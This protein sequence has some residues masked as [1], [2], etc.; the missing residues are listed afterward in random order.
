MRPTTPATITKAAAA[1]AQTQ[2]LLKAL[3][4]ILGW[5]LAHLPEAL[6]RTLVH[7]LGW[8]I[9]TLPRKRRRML[10]SNLHHAFPEKTE[11]AR[12][13][14]A[15]ES[16]RRLAEMLTFVVSSPF[17]P[18]QQILG[19]FS[20]SEALGT[21]TDEVRENQQA[22]ILAIPHFTLMDAISIL[23]IL[24]NK[25]VPETGVLFRALANPTLDAWMRHSRER[26]GVVMLARR[27][28][29]KQ[30]VER[31]K[32]RGPVAL[33]FDQN[34][35]NQGALSLCFGR[36]ASISEMAGSLAANHRTRV[37]AMWPERRGFWRAQIQAEPI[38][39][40]QDATEIN[41]RVNRWLERKLRESDDQAADW[42]WLHNRWRTQDE[43][44]RRLRIEH[45]RSILERTLELDGLTEIPR[46]TRFW[47]RLPNWLGDV[48]MTLPL[49]RALRK[50]RPDAA[51][52]L[53]CQPGVKPFLEM[54]GIAEEVRALPPKD[55]PNRWQTIKGW[56]I[57]YP[58]TQ[59]LFTN[60]TRGDLEAKRIGAPQR[61]GLRRPGKRRPLLT[62]GWD[63]PADLDEAQLHQTH[64]WQRFLEHFGLN[65]A[66]DYAPFSLPLKDTAPTVDQAIGWICGTE[67]NPEKRWP[68]EH[69]RALAQAVLD[70][71][72]IEQVV[73]FGTPADRAITER[74]AQGFPAER[75]LNRAGETNLMQF[76]KALTRCRAIICND[77]GG[78]HL[79]NA[80][81]VPVLAIFGPTNPIRTGPI[82]EAPRV[83]LQPPSCPPTGGADIAG[84]SVEHV[85]Q[86]LRALLENPPR[87]LTPNHPGTSSEA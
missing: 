27:G 20:R 83:L 55:A 51:L 10:L 67:N 2:T 60:S 79:A 46:R 34:A 58:D 7:W 33:L 28:G 53:L 66:P 76:A 61:F 47:V 17:L 59:I 30:A 73:L 77:T 18:K 26:W 72:L 82:F 38:D 5:T 84:V 23:P 35:G 16:S 78:M 37:F 52:T 65:A 68:I 56:R 4:I 21:Y 64:L 69:W 75:I 13:A 50:S 19:R 57:D 15:R 44:H 81:G 22:C 12:V 1:S 45:R 85:L 14:I 54:L 62:H 42:L 87:P 6:V 41:I 32:Q 8:L 31:L 3:V 39:D 9:Y 49:L 29:L 71:N 43:P 25:E 63:V 80:L 40:W 74:V 24:H 36:V 86:A 11:A 70:V 48:I